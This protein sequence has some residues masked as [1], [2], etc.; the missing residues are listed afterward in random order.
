M[1]RD[2]FW[3]GWGAKDFILHKVHSDRAHF[4][5][6]AHFAHLDT[7]AHLHIFLHLHTFYTC[8]HFNT[9]EHSTLPHIF[10]SFLHT[11]LQTYT[12]L[13]TC[14]FLNILHLHTFAHFLHLHTL[15]HTLPHFCTFALYIIFPRI[16]AACAKTSVLKCA[17]LW[18]IVRSVQVCKIM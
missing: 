12:L 13:H 9:L 7:F 8:T 15:F 6:L 17:K 16:L 18:A 14:T 4:C 3:I 11:I 5:T 2:G 10:Y 1:Q